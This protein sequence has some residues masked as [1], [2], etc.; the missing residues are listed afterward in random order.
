MGGSSGWAPGWDIDDLVIERGE[1]NDASLDLFEV[2]HVD[3]GRGFAGV[4]TCGSDDV[5]NGI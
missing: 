2:W 5:E 3:H 4:Q 1:K